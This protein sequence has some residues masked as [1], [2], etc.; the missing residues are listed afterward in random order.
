MNETP[1]L[2]DTTTELKCLGAVL[3]EGNQAAN[4][5]ME[6]FY[7]NANRDLAM[8]LIGM[9]GNGQTVTPESADIEAG[10][11]AGVGSLRKTILAAMDSTPCTAT[12]ELFA[13]D[14]EQLATRRAIVAACARTSMAAEDRGNPTSEVIAA[15]A[16]DALTIERNHHAMETELSNREVMR[17]IIDDWDEALKQGKPSG[18]STGFGCIDRILGPM[19]PGQMIV[20]AARPGVGK[21]SLATCIAENLAIRRGLPVGFISLEM[22]HQ[23]LLARIVAGLAGV[24]KSRLDSGTA[25]QGDLVSLSGAMDRARNAPIHIVDRPGQ[26]VGKIAA[27]A[28]RLVHG[29]GLRLLVID[30]L[31]LIRPDNAKQRRYELVTDTSNALKV[32]AKELAIPVI[33]LSQ[34]NREADKEDSPPRLIHLRDSG[35]IE[36]DADAVILLHTQDGS[37]SPEVMVELN[38]A[39]NRSGPVGS[40]RLRFNRTLTRFEES[41]PSPVDD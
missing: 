16:N 31:G 18:L 30:Y 17:K 6:W 21:T 10:R 5:R 11:Q 29:L 19:R 25:S 8:L 38:I 2:Y 32:L 9:A 27:T 41:A 20:I 35:A 3:M 23:E 15:F 40:A 1:K 26:T 13:A 22:S 28:R 33:V 7:E 24:D 14:L 36:Q 37:H 39:K 34:L 12:F 4:L